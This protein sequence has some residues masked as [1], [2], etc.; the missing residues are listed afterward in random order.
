MVVDHNLQK[1]YNCVMAS[2]KC[3]VF[4]ADSSPSNWTVWKLHLCY[5]VKEDYQEEV[6]KVYT[7]YPIES[8]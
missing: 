3:L 6:M 8:R 1:C 4:S 7:V 2:K 5:F